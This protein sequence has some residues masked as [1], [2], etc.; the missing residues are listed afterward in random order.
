MRLVVAPAVALG[1]VLLLGLSGAAMQ[2][3]IS[4]SGAPTAV[5]MT[6]LATEYEVEPSF[7]TAAVFTSTLLSPLT[8]TP[9]I[10]WLGA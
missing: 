6:I 7:V 10:A 3:A 9:L 5:F 2:A 8:M 4:E 1:I